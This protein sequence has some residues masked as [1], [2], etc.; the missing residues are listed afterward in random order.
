MSKRSSK[1]S[2]GTWGLVFQIGN[3]VVGLIRIIR[4]LLGM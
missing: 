1:D 2:T 3:F 4:D